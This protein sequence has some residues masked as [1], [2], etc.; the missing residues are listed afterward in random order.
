MLAIFF[1]SYVFFF[2]IIIKL[3]QIKKKKKLTFNR[4]QLLFKTVYQH[5]IFQKSHPLS[6]VF[7]QTL[8]NYFTQKYYSFQ[9]LAFIIINF[10]FYFFIKQ[11]KVFFFFFFL[12]NMCSRIERNS[13]LLIKGK[14][15]SIAF[16][17]NRIM[18]FNIIIIIATHLIIIIIIHSH[19]LFCVLSFYFIRISKINN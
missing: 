1:F 13:R 14:K 4:T 18:D 7:S 19:S 8:L 10:L 2:F 15:I 16:L 12:I 11:K 5:R 3:K 9:S 6:T 17:S